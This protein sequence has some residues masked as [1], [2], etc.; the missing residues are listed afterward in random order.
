MLKNLTDTDESWEVLLNSQ[1][2]MHLTDT[3]DIINL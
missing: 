2:L 3:Y 1:V